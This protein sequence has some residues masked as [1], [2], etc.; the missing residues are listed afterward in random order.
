MRVFTLASLIG[1]LVDDG[2]LLIAALPEGRQRRVHRARGA[3]DHHHDLHR[4]SLRA[5]AR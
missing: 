3:L 1:G 2:T 4:G 5:T